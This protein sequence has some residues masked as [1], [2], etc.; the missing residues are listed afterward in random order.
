MD[1]D[2]R[3]GRR[4]P[5]GWPA[6]RV[7]RLRSLARAAVW[8]TDEPLDRSDLTWRGQRDLDHN[9]LDQPESEILDLLEGQVGRRDCFHDWLCAGYR[10]DRADT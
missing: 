2:N 5:S 7:T 1:A 8:L 3:N 9:R 6:P 10:Q 4:I